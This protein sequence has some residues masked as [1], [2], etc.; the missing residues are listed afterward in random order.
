MNRTAWLWSVGLVLTI[1][2][3][4]LLAAFLGEVLAMAMGCEVDFPQL[5]ACSRDTD[6]LR[7]FAIWL[8]AMIRWAI[9]TVPTA[10]LTLVGLAITFSVLKKREKA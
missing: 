5:G 6:F 8:M 7:S 9:I 2:L 4:P 3:A 1:G 10:I